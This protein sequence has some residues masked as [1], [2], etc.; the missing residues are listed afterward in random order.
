MSIYFLYTL[1][2]LELIVG[3]MVI[4]VILDFFPLDSETKAF[5]TWSLLSR[6]HFPYRV[7]RFPQTDHKFCK[8]TPVNIIVSQKNH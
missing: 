7:S 6:K 8:E 3:F 2:V 4:F 1:M 5:S